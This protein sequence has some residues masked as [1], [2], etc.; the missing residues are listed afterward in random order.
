MTADQTSGVDLELLLRRI[1]RE[2]T[3]LTEATPADKWRGGSL[4]LRPGTPGCRREAGR[5]SVLP[6]GRDAAEPAA[7]ARAADQ[8]DGDSGRREGPASVLCHRLLRLFTASTFSSP[9]RTISFE[10]SPPT[11]RAAPAR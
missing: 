4:V 5:S 10:A 1:I 8:R 3:G 9:K 7:H 11:S 2:E 6:Q